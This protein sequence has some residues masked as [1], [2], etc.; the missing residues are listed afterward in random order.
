LKTIG[1]IISRY[2][3]FLAALLK[4]LG[5]WGVF[6]IAGIDSSFLGMPLD[7]VVAGYIYSNPHKFLLYVLM[8]SIGSSL[9]SLIIYG[10]G[11]RGGEALLRKRVSAERFEK[12]HNGFEEHPF[13]TL[14]LPA[15]LPPPTPFKLFVLGAGVS[16]MRFTQFLLAI[17]SGRF[18]RFVILGVLTLL[19][20]PQF[21][22]VAGRVFREHFSVV[23][24]VAI[25]A[26][27]V[28]LIMRERTRRRRRH[29]DA[30]A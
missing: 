23:A 30:A 16:E 8:A 21:I 25:G 28:W 19:F 17:F 13:W 3:A 24:G 9:G 4:P 10:I 5:S 26:I 29:T 2:T 1:H 11:Y 12:I 7:F 20:G 15:M 18:I 14:M 22:E 27:T 6:A